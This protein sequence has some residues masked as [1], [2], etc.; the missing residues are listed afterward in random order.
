MKTGANGFF[1]LRP[2]GPGTW[3]SV[4]AGVVQLEP[5]DVAPLLAGLRDAVAPEVAR[6]SRFL[7]RP[8]EPSRAALAYV[9]LGRSLGVDRRPTCASRRTWW[10]VAPDRAPAPVLY[11][12]KVGTRA[13]AFHN[14]EG[15]LED[16]KWHAL[17]PRELEPWLLA[18]VLSATPLRLAVERA[19]RQLTGAQAIA[20]IDC[21]VLGAAPF[22]A[23]RALAAFEGVLRELHGAL[24]RDPVTTDLAAMLARPAQRELDRAVG[25]A[26]GLSR[27]EVEAERRELFRRS[28]ERLARAGQVRAA[29]ARV[30][31]G[32]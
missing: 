20:D 8:V 11:P 7:F 19:A 1:H 31:R 28:E 24:A 32:A 10:R 30:G 17:F 5:G 6:P 27:G 26:L 23:D 9:A 18:V 3:R 14:R 29:I 15:L 12:A 25:A 16:K 21:G 2:E 13:F 4:A 22:P